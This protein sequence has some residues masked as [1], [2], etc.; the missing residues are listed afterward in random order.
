MM[1]RYR[2]TEIDGNF[3]LSACTVL[4]TKEDVSIEEIGT[5]KPKPFY[6]DE[7]RTFLYRRIENPDFNPKE[8]ESFENLPFA[9]E[10]AELSLGVIER[11][12]LNDLAEAIVA[13][14]NG[15]EVSTEKIERCLKK[16]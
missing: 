3:W 11:L 10:K 1:Y 8:R 9:L 2:F 12:T 15:K 16:K 13:L 5:F 4:R 7:T 14:K 6:L